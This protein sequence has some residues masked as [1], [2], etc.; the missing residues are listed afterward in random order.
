MPQTRLQKYIYALITVILT[1]P[2][3]VFYCSSY[4]AG[5]FAIDVMLSSAKFIPIE[6]GLAYLCEVFF[7][8]PVSAKLALRAVDPKKNSPVLVQTAVICANVAIMCPLMSLLATIMYGGIIGVGMGGAPLDVYLMNFI[9]SWLQ[10]VVLNFPFAIFLQLFY[11]QP[12]V[13][14]IFGVVFKKE[15]AKAR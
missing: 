12:L 2:C 15:M 3:F 1:V 8:T 13:R 6:F 10:T 9:P 14:K 4:E 5:G 7:V 11:V